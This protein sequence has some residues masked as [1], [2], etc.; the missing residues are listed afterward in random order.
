MKLID[1]VRIL[2][3]RVHRVLR[4]IVV[5]AAASVAAAQ[6]DS[7][8]VV[9]RAADTAAPTPTEPA[10]PAEVVDP[11][12][13]VTNA[14]DLIRGLTSYAEM[15]MLIKRPSWERSSSLVAWTRGREDAL[16]RFTA[17]AK[18]AGNAM[19]KTG[20]KMWTYTPRLNRV[21]RLPYSLMSQSWAGSDF[22][23][24]DL[25]RTDALLH[26]YQLTLTDTRQEGERTV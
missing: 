19:L 10:E 22:S 25:S 15:S 21:I 3:L 20:E 4:M 6:A 18:D 13:L 11:V 14:I 5:L 8:G 12:E 2:S 7:I 17:P 9:D 24:N 23:Y 1:Q 16:I 26:Q